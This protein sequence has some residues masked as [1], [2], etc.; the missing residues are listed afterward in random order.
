MLPALGWMAV[1]YSLSSLT[2]REVPSGV[3]DE[4]AGHA[5]EYA[6]LA[7]LVM[8]AVAGLARPEVRSHHFVIAGAV[9]MTWAVSDEWHQ[10]FVP[11]R[12]PSIRD[13]AF[14]A[15]GASLA[16]VLLALALRRGRR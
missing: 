13:L 4:R 2:S 9:S 7:I 5:L 3:I 11:G 14:D 10:S 12:D 8:I 6:I 1:I 16:L 15:I